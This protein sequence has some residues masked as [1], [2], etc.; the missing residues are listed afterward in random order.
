M[1]NPV[2][3]TSTGGGPMRDARLSARPPHRGQRTTKA[4]SSS[5]VW[6][7]NVWLHSEHAKPPRIDGA[8]PIAETHG[9]GCSLLV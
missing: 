3:V 8:A 2:G 4:A 9:Y 7:M 6:G 1:I 5:C